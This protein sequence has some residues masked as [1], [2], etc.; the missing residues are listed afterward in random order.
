MTRCRSVWNVNL[1]ISEY[2]YIRKKET[3]GETKAKGGGAFSHYL[4]K[5]EL[6]HAIAACDHDPIL[7]RAHKAELWDKPHYDQIFN[8]GS[9]SL[10]L[11]KY[12]TLRAAGKIAKSG[13]S[14]WTYMKWLMTRFRMGE[15]R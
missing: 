8:G 14:E 12:W 13:P 5:E 6:A 11:A 1:G 15:T 10:K 9:L 2:G 7:V 3:K 4:S